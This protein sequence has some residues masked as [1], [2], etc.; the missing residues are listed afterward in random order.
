MKTTL[1]IGLVL[2]ATLLM[3]AP[4]ASADGDD[5]PTVDSVTAWA[6]TCVG[7]WPGHF[8]PVFVDVGSCLDVT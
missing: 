3:T 1:A 7:I 2:T 8:P 6:S 4:V 5:L